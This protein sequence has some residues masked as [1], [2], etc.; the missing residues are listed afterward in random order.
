[1]GG[2]KEGEKGR[3]GGE[4]SE[5]RKKRGEREEGRGERFEKRV[6]GQVCKAKTLPASYY[7]KHCYLV[8]VF[9]WFRQRY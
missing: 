2:G 6:L 1:V 8:Y 7:F 3:G 4:S 9:L 5:R